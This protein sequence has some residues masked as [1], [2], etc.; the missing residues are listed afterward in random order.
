MSTASRR[1]GCTLGLHLLTW[2]AASA[3]VVSVA[4]GEEPI[5]VVMLDHPAVTE[6]SG[7]AFSNVNGD[8]LWTHNDSGDTARLFAFDRAGKST[9]G[10]RL[11]GVE[12][13]D[14]EDMA[15]FQQDSVARLVVADVG[16]NGSVRPLVSLYFFDEPDP[17]QQT[18]ITAWSRI[19]ICYADGPRDCEAIMVDPR[20]SIV[21][22][23]TKS[24]LGSAGV[25]EL[26]LP[27]RLADKATPESDGGKSAGVTAAGQPTHQVQTLR[28]LAT[29]TIPL[30][31]AAD[32]DPVSGDHLLTNYFQLFRFPAGEPERPWWEFSP[33]ATDLPRWKQIEAIAVDAAGGVWVT[34]EGS[35]TP[36]AK[37]PVAPQP[38]P[39]KRF[40]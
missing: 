19:D 6:S 31:T 2:L 26:P 20:R 38:K 13:I 18:E 22:L 4:T 10:C 34:S 37:I 30:V 17:D 33:T 35:P 29:L 39:A 27:P 21:T 32:R 7:L 15:A 1:V 36:L 40:P 14:F 28:R 3:L 8:R 12:A 11:V 23:V 25:Y 24:F 9:G 16:D 5:V